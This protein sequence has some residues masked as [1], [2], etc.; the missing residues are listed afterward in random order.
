MSIEEL[1]NWAN[2]NYRLSMMTTKGER[3]YPDKMQITFLH[4]VTSESRIYPI[5]THIHLFDKSEINVAITQEQLRS[6]FEWSNYDLHEILVYCMDI[7]PDNI[8]A[9][10]SNTSETGSYLKI[11]K[12]N[13]DQIKIPASMFMFHEINEMYVILVDKTQPKKQGILKT[14]RTGAGAHR[15]CKTTKRVAFRD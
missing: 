3:E 10:V 8:P 9:F 4:W 1:E 11:Y 13:T 15:F 5:H 12:P 14:R 6:Y 2:E 7:E